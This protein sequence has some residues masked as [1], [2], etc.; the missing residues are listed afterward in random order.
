ME[1]VKI[2]RVVADCEQGMAYNEKILFMYLI[3]ANIEDIKT[4]HAY[5]K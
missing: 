2:I 3:K 5:I 4:L 1:M